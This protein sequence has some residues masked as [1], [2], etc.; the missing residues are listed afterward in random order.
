MPTW[1]QV[2]RRPRWLAGLALALLIAVVFSLLGQ[3]QLSR[4]FSTVG[5]ADPNPEP[6]PLSELVEP[7]GLVFREIL[8]RPATAEVAIDQ[9]NLFIVGNRIQVGEN[10]QTETGYWLIANSRA[11]VDDETVSL[12]LAL[13]FSADLE[14][15][16]AAREELASA[17]LVT[18]FM[19]VT[20][21]VEPTEA[22]RDNLEPDVFGSLS[23]AQL[24]NLYSAEPF[25]SYPVFLI[26]DERSTSS[27]LEPIKIG[28]QSETVE[29]NWLTLF[30]AI[31]WVLFALAAFYIWGRLVAD[32]R[33]REIA[34]AGA[35]GEGLENEGDRESDTSPQT[36]P[37]R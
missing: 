24:V 13:G 5:Q 33:Q 36:P 6:V 21:L 19:P 28:L 34:E 31:E 11:L 26:V 8:D 16:R 7:G 23:L 4:S 14:L 1:W 18:A 9:S 3:W 37:T 27:G 22:P 35:A 30:Y 25:V 17:F 29:I 10:E 15:V 20:G 32:A 12:T 2:A